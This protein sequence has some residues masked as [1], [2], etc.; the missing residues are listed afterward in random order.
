[1]DRGTDKPTATDMEPGES[2]L[3]KDAP[4][5]PGEERETTAP[6]EQESAEAPATEESTAEES[7][8]TESE[9][10]EETEES[11]GL[12]TRTEV[13]ELGPW[14]RRIL[15]AVPRD[16]VQEH[17]DRNYRELASSVQIPGFRRGRVPR[18]LL[19]KRYGE[20]I[21]SDVK[22][23]LL[24]ESFQEVLKSREL[25]IFGSPRF[26]NIQFDTEDDFRYEVEIEVQPEFDLPEY[27][28]LQ[29][30]REAV[31]V[32]E[33]V[34][35]EELEKLRE[36][37][38]TL[39]PVNAEEAGP[40]DFYLGRYELYVDGTQ[41][42]TQ[43]DV[44]F[45]PASERIV[46]F[47]VEGLADRVASWK[48]ADNQPL[49]VPVRVPSDYSDEVLREKDAEL[50]FFLLDAKR[51]KLPEL[52]DEFANKL[53]RESIAEARKDLRATLERRTK[54]KEDQRL[55]AL[56][57]DGLLSGVDFEIPDDIIERHAKSEGQPDDGA[58]E[59]GSA[60]ETGG[61]IVPEAEASEDVESDEPKKA[62][63][64]EEAKDE[65]RRRLKEF[66]VLEVIA[67]KEKIYATEDE[68]R[69]QVEMMAALYG[70]DAK[71][72]WNT[73]RDTGGLDELRANLR[74][75][76]VKA[77]LLKKAKV[78]EAAKGASENA[79]E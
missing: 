53:G 18:R 30:E 47:P 57:V 34:V 46:E 26:D 13:E 36:Q 2:K 66:F 38:R 75:D 11:E 6:E 77:F 65:A 72:L 10:S 12:G 78:V 1:M 71:N 41:V 68:V 54:L 56:L 48:R 55:Q 67:E 8:D 16:T 22:D 3:S 32:D 4:E 15:A 24:T 42:K 33:K 45:L 25:K 51:A 58:E 62:E 49:V 69:K 50:R 9:E 39:L 59:T 79:G 21:N 40:D 63:T 70:T 28:G 43:D 20:D 29:V 5:E 19:E 14:K 74:S 7:V 37:Q 44:E 60:Q 64:S 31:S 61:A 27:K 76:K 35:D 73:L 52:D 17:L 23:T